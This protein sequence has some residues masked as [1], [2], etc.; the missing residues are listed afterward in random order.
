MSAITEENR[1]VV[2]PSREIPVLNAFDVIVC[3][4]GPAGLTAAVAAARNGAK[5]LLI[6]RYGF[7]GGMATSALVTPISEFRHFGKQHI[8]GIPFELLRMAADLGGADVSRE[9]GNFPVNDEILKLAAQRLLLD[10]GVTLLYHTWFSDCV[11]EGDRLT[12]VIVQNKTGR[13]AYKAEA[14]ID[15]TGDADLVRAA[16]LPTVKGD[17]LQP[18]TLWFQLGGVDTASLDHLFGDAKD[19]M[20]PVSGAIRGRLLEL[21][22]Q[23]EI[24]FFGGPWIN[25]FFHDGMVS[26]NLL[27]EATDASDPEW[28]TRTECSLRE[29]LHHF[30]AVLRREFPEFRDCWL[31]KSGIQ[32]GVRESYRIVGLYELQRDDILAPKAFPDT[33]AKGAH[34]IDIHATDS[35]EQNGLVVPRQ[36]YNIPLRCLVP[37]GSVNLITAG[38]C[39][40]ADGSGFGSARVMATCMAM[41]QGAGTAAALGVTHGYSM[42]DMNFSLLRQ[43]LI[44]QG[45]V[46]DFDNAVAPQAPIE[47]TV[48]PAAMRA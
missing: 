47:V 30:I 31:A 37:Q 27:R 18:A 42:S 45:A 19:G 2:E 39:L 9:S 22:A 4:G 8:G 5:T 29:T 40:S 7:V 41:G 21:N 25:S 48:Y 44:E 32:T 26:I 17:V 38:R 1:P 20:L 11:M 24:P 14:F 3:G 35:N 12:H 34:V 46:V 43:R 16:G 28:F 13:V 23:G 33:V 15:C 10:S 36:E 6:E